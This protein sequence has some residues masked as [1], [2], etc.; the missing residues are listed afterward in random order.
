MTDSQTSRL[1]SFGITPQRVEN[2]AQGVIFVRVE[3]DGPADRAGLRP[4]RRDRRG[5]V[6]LGDIII[7]IDGEPVRSRED[8]TLLLEQKEEG[9]R[10]TYLRGDEEEQ[11]EVRLEV[12]E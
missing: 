9:D 4:L 6:T 8:L 10:V 12:P 1:T 5:R 2:S 3:P 7:G 11:V